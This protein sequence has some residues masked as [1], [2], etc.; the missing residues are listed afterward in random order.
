LALPLDPEE[1]NASVLTRAFFGHDQLMKIR[2]DTGSVLHAR[3]GTYGGIRPG[4]RVQA[5][6][7]GAVL[8]YPRAE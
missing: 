7:R 2:L 1:A 3:L 6:V 5:S 8:T 4:D